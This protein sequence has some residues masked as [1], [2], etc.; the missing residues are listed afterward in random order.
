MA[1]PIL[2]VDKAGLVPFQEDLHMLSE[3]NTF[4][5]NHGFKSIII[6]FVAGKDVALSPFVYGT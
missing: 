1:E 4:S 5:F 3:R 6:G 2:S